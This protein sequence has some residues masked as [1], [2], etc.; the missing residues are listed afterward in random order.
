MK[1]EMKVGGGGR[2]S[3]LYL[4]SLVLVCAFS[5]AAALLLF[6]VRC[7][8]CKQKKTNTPLNQQRR[9]PPPIPPFRLHNQPLWLLH[10]HR[11]VP[12]LE[13]QQRTAAQQAAQG[14]GVFSVSA[15]KPHARRRQR[16]DAGRQ[17]ARVLQQGRAGRRAAR[18]AGQG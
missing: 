6:G 9:P 4:C 11:H 17:R 12:K 5:P 16:A 13:G 3:F 8:V 1:V 14:R 15:L 7:C 18:E 10:R 2:H